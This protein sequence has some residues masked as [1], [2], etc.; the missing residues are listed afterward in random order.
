MRSTSHRRATSDPA[1]S[2]I[3]PYH[4]LF[5]TSTAW[6]A[7][8]KNATKNASL[9]LRRASLLLVLLRTNLRAKL[10]RGASVQS[11]NLSGLES[12]TQ[13]HFGQAYG[14]REKCRLAGSPLKNGYIKPNT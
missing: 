14:A 13:G 12:T 5:I 2:A 8:L 4:A 7:L 6:P 1:L 10:E 9:G 11:R 3:A